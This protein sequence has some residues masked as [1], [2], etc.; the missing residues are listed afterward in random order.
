MGPQFQSPITINSDPTSIE[1]LF[2]MGL[3][4]TGISVAVS[5]QICFSFNCLNSTV[6]SQVAYNLARNYSKNNGGDFTV[7][8]L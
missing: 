7:L 1:E 4:V 3:P 6:A 8:S 5:P 2:E